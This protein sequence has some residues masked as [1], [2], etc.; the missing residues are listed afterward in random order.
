MNTPVMGPPRSQFV[1]GGQAKGSHGQG[2][3]AGA[4]VV[5]SEK[6]E[7]SSGQASKDLSGQG[8]SPE[9]APEK[10]R[11]ALKRYFSQP[12]AKP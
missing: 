6:T 8:R 4:S 7:P 1:P 10:Y 2:G 5:R 11:K 3:Q 9:L 12:E